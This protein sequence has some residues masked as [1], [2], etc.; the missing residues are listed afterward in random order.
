MLQLIVSG[1]PTNF[2]RLDDSISLTLGAMFTLT[3]KTFI[4]GVKGERHWS[5]WVPKHKTAWVEKQTAKSE[6]TVIVTADQL[7]I[8]SAGVWCCRLM[9][10]QQI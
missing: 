4:D 8:T 10:L 7:T 2:E 1:K 6:Y 3:Q 5:V 9:E